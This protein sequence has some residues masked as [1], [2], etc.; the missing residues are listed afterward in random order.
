VKAIVAAPA[1]TMAAIAKRPIV[2]NDIDFKC[3]SAIF[4]VVSLFAL[5]A[6]RLQSLQRSFPAVVPR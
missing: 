2:P 3:R 5:W 6:Q 1:S 4:F